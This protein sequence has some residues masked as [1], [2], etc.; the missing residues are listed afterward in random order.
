MLTMCYVT[1]WHRFYWKRLSKN[2]KSR[3]MSLDY[4]TSQFSL[5]YLT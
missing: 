4:L 2:G 5:H 1:D 3:E